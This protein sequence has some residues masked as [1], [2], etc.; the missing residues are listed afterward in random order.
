M[1]NELNQSVQHS[2]SLNYLIKQTI[3]HFSGMPSK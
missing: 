1:N 3:T 2:K